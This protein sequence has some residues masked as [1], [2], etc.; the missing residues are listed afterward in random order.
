MRTLLLLLAIHLFSFKSVRAD[1]SLDNLNTNDTLG[2]QRELSANILHT[3]VD[4]ARNIYSSEPDTDMFQAGLMAGMT[5]SPSLNSLVQEQDSSETSFS[6]LLYL[7]ALFT[8]DYKWGL[9]V[10]FTFLPNIG[11]GDI[12]FYNYAAAIEWTFS[13]FSLL[14]QYIKLPFDSSLKLHGQVAKLRGDLDIN[15][16][17][18]G[19]QTVPARL[20]VQ[21]VVYGASLQ[22]SKNFFERFEPFAS[23]G[24]LGSRGRYDVNSS[25]SSNVAIFENE[26]NEPLTAVDVQANSFVATAGAQLHYFNWRLGAE[27]TSAFSTY[28]VAAKLA[29]AF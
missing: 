23:L 15:N 8:V 5:N 27:Y 22:V 20:T 14:R 2:I 6:Q 19:N 10:E 3:S 11:V 9:S 26:K 7:G 24:V 28:R 13:D 21:N 29:A 17:S 18:T 12:R 1:F 4:S 25:Q 16:T